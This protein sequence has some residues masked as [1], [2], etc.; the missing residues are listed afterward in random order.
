MTK[1]IRIKMTMLIQILEEAGHQ[2]KTIIED[3][4]GKISMLNNLFLQQI[5]YQG[6]IVTKVRLPPVAMKSA[7]QLWQ[8]DMVSPRMNTNIYW[9]Y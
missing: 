8:R 7:M 5:I 9:D 3:M 1:N 6:N 4:Q 2:I